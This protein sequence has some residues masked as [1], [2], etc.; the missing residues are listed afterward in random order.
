MQAGALH[1]K[2]RPNKLVDFKGEINEGIVESLQ[3]QLQ[4]NWEQIPRSFLFIGP[5]GCGKTS[6]ARI[7]A[8]ELGCSQR[9]F[10]ELNAANTRGIDTIREISS[11]CK[12]APF[13]GKLRAYLIDETAAVTK[14]GQ[15]ALLKLLEDTP[16]HVFLF[17]CTTDPQ[18]LLETIKNRCSVYQVGLWEINELYRH[19]KEIVNIEGGKCSSKVIKRVAEEAGG[20]PRK[21]LTMLDQV[22]L[23]EDDQKALSLIKDHQDDD[24]QVIEI[25]RLIIAKKSNDKWDKMRSLVKNYTGEPESVRK[26]ILGYLRTTI[27]NQ[28]S[29]ND[30]ANRAVYLY[31]LMLDKTWMYD[32][33]DVMINAL[34]E[35]CNY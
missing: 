32:G 4:K 10:H 3:Q 35:A 30:F 11:N 1:L 29:Q 15:V 28:A 25:C 9:D 23:M 17:L 5:S 2:Y 31:G 24:T 6:L 34:Y 19:L 12:M 7:V 33:K 27:L 14:D 26:A 18:N 16:A 13:E 20:S 8:S 21:A 22:I